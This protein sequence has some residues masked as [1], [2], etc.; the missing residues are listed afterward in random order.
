MFFFWLGFLAFGGFWLPWL[1][2]DICNIL[3][4]N[5][6]CLHGMQ[7]FGPELVSFP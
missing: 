5:L 4:L 2:R 1:L 7:R 6:S 3:D